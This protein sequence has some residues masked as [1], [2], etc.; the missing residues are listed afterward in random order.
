[1]SQAF[2]QEPHKLLVIPG[3]IEVTDEVLY[4]N[5]RPPL[6]HTGADFIP[7][8]GDCLRMMRDV[9]YTE[10]GQPFLVA[11]SGTLGWDMAA[12]NL[13][14]AGE[15]VLLLTTGYFGDAFAECYEAY[16]A[17]VDLIRAP[18][19]GAV[20]E[21]EIRAA[22]KAKK[23][24]V[25]TFTHVDTS[26]GV[27]S[28]AKMIGEVV[29]E[30]SPDTLIVLDG[31]C[32]VASEQILFDTWGIDVVVSASQKGLGAPPGLSVLMA[33]QRA[34]NTMQNRKVPVSSY[35]ASWKKWL[36][37]MQAYEKGLPAY[38]ATPPVNLVQAFHASLTAITK[39]VPNLQTRFTMHKEAS[40]KIKGA[41][42]E[43]GLELLT[44]DPYYSANGMSAVKYPTGIKMADLIPRLVKKNIVVTGGLHKDVKDTYFR[45]G[46]M[47]TTVV[48]PERGDIEKVISGVKEALSEAGYKGKM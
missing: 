21:S 17:K 41:M 20:P 2:H 19:G 11:G 36:P 30:V 12:S 48:N 40:A 7:I 37:I 9:L 24:K 6:A 10:A 22:L 27:L 35:Y 28:D 1:M 39:G 26:T 18:I 25:L 47:G 29:R 4:A 38:F 34:I 46:H 8:F 3:P 16:G 42:Q 14:E 45:I 13:V 33:S 32:A 5:A 43:L 15:D 23:Y 44:L 31:V